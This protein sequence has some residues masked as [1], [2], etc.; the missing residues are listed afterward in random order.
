LS[1]GQTAG[2]GFARRK[3][4]R[5]RPSFPLDG[6]GRRGRACQ[7]DVGFQADQLLR[8]RLYPIDV[9]AA[10]P[11]V[12][13]HV[14]AI[15]PTQVRKRSRERGDPSLPLRIVFVAPD[16]HADPSHPFALLRPGRQWPRRGTPEPRDELPPSD[17]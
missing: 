5:D 16:E 4:D 12:D 3:D 14:A 9:T 1:A 7:D 11:K 15:G 2:G 10:P 8:E 6:S 13:L 17:H